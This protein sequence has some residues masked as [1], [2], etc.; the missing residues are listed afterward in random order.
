MNNRQIGPKFY[1]GAT[2]GKAHNIYIDG[3]TLYSYGKHFPMAVRLTPDVYA[4][5]EDRYSV[6]TSKQQGQ[7]YPHGKQIIPGDT[8]ILQLW[9][10]FREFYQP[11]DRPCR[12]ARAYML[13]L[14]YCAEHVAEAMQKKQRARTDNMR[15]HWQREA[16]RYQAAAHTLESL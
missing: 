1:D 3:H 9:A 8:E 10:T 4:W 11:A 2:K 6:T 16:E 7:C 12:D 15:D 14:K 13:T 5:N